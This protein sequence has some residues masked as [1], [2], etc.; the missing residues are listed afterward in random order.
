MVHNIDTMGADVDP[1]LLGY[2]IAEGAALTTEVIARQ[3]EDRGGGLARVDGR[4]RLVEGLALPSEEV[5]SRLS[6]YNSATYWID[7]DQLLAMF[8]LTRDDL[9]DTEKVNDAVRTLAARMPTYITLKDVKKRWGKGQED[10]FPVAQFEKLWGDMTGLAGIGLPLCGR[11]P[12]ARPATQRTGA[13]RRLAA[14]RLG[15]LRR[16]PVRLG[17]VNSRLRRGLRSET[18]ISEVIR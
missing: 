7:I 10:V 11:A 14:R 17:L 4:V 8:G 9:C 15:R 5:E 16:V 6:W 3:V 18:Q 12:Q 13:A 2:H 1:G